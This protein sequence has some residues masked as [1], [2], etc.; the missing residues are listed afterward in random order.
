MSS[1]PITFQQIRNATG[2]IVYNG[3]TILVDPIL[4]PKGEYPGFELATSPERKKM[5]N[6]LIELPVPVEEVLK[7]LDAV[8]LT[9]THLDH[10]EAYAAKL[11]PKYIPIFVQHAADKKLVQSQGFLDV[12]VTGI[13]TPF[14]GITITKTGGQHGTDEMFAVPTIAELLDESMGFV[15]RAPGQK[16]IYFAG[17]TRWH[18]Y[19]EL[20]LNKYK[21]DYILLNTGEATYDGFD[22]SLIMGTAD[23]KKCYDF[24]KSVKIITV[25][26]DAINHCICT[27][28]IMRK[29]VEENKL[30]DRVLI[31]SDGETLTL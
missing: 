4:C 9:H 10:W 22:G 18:E 1:K 30:G 14:K 31:P 24:C 12:R 27:K 16:N 17:D 8:I 20:A 11:I 6:P 28:A 23:V 29:F 15:L 7:D 26:M 3:L 5:R 13:N 25:H 21:P 2:R 19:V